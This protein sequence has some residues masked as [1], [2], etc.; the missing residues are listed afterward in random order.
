MLKFFALPAFCYFLL[1]C[2][3]YA[4]EYNSVVI[5]EIMADP[6]PVVGLPDAEYLEIYNRS[7][8][9]V[10]LKGWKLVTG[11]RTSVLPDSSIAPGLYALICLS[12]KAGL[13]SKYG[14]VI[15]L[16]SFSL[17][18]EGLSL[19]LYNSNN[20]LVYSI[21]Y[22]NKWWVSEK[23]D[24][25]FSI[26]M[27]DVGNPCGEGE[28]W[29]TSVDKSGGTP[30]LKS[31]IS[32]V[33]RDSELPFVERIDVQDN[34]QLLI[35]FNKRMDSLNVVA[36]ATIDLPG[37]KIIR[38]QLDLPLFHILR[39]TLDVSLLKDQEYSL[40]IRNVADCSGNLLRASVHRVGLPSPAD[41]G[42]VVINEVLFNPRD[43]GVDFVE[44]YNRSSRFINLKNWTIGNI[45]TDGSSAFNLITSA[46]LL[47]SP[48]AYL[49][50]TT[51]PKLVKEQYSSGLQANFFE[52][53]ALPSLPNT[54][55]GVILRNAGSG[56]FDRFLYSEKMH[57]ELLSGYE[58]VSLEK[59]D[60]DVSS[61]VTGNWQSASSV[62][63]YATPG[64]A[65][66]QRRLEN[67]EYYFK[68]EPEAF[69]PDNDGQDDFAVI[70]YKQHPAALL[71]TI[72]IFSVNGRLVRNLL[73]NELIGTNG[74]VSW[75]GTDEYG[76]LVPTGYY[77]VLIDCFDNFGKSIQYKKRVVVA[78][79]NG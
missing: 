10:S 48:H 49:V 51:D 26:E 31:S 16:T 70:K 37:R 38:K 78:R 3:C 34:G 41:S 66:S 19:G 5:S 43:S 22:T 32:K 2:K 4:Q 36:G 35:V 25:G 73:R 79:K 7:E 64:Y 40:S 47:I 69:S 14:K 55:G 46:D 57:H 61:S 15:G 9:V 29:I 72:R 71:G 52:T 56:E 18:N 68:I 12:S 54:E 28:N 53:S 17:T 21:F 20:K 24:G 8:K 74:E 13:L 11:A 39:L 44:L 67:P 65:N 33:T 75:D 63:E 58:G 1:L 59:V 77:L 42:D 45:K 27:V 23:K 76:Q 60:S 50:V 30:G 62:T 6:S